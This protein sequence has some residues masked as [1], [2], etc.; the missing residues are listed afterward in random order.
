M[1]R[2][3][4]VGTTVP[5]KERDGNRVV[6]ALRAC[7]LVS[8]LDDT[9]VA[10]IASGAAT[11]QVKANSHLFEEGE[12]CTGLWVLT[13]GRVRLLHMMADGRQHA[14]GFHAPTTPL[15]LG[16]ALDGRPYMATAVTLVD[17]EVAFVPRTSLV[18]MG[19]DYPV[20]IRNAI[21]LLCAE[22]RQRDIAAAVGVLKDARGRI[23][24][25][26]LQLARQFGVTSD[27][28]IRINYPLTRQHIADRSGVTVE[29][30]I[31]V[32]SELQQQG[33]IQTDNQI[34]QILDIPRLSHALDCG[35][36]QLECSVFSQRPAAG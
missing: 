7:A 5:G 14:V 23:G 36:C 19:R 2:A 1:L 17:S 35:T 24:C 21:Q 12:N 6:V 16:A 18:D 27:S 33:I 29:T 11:H 34:I 32:M 15:D 3:S 20:T 4:G 13:S 10:E 8:G 31:R 9:A 28:A 30:A 26:L 25:T 22:V